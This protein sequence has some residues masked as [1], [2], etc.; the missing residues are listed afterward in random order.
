[1]AETLTQINQRMM[2]SA[3]ATIIRDQR[4]VDVHN[5]FPKD[6][7]L[8]LP[9]VQPKLLHIDDAPPF[10]TIVGTIDGIRESFGP[11]VGSIDDVREFSY[12]GQAEC[13]VMTLQVVE[14]GQTNRQVFDLSGSYSTY[15]NG[16]FDLK[17]G[18]YTG[19]DYEYISGDRTEN[20]LEI[21]KRLAEVLGAISLS[22]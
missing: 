17:A 19:D 15:Y 18:E 10:S 6:G 12:H 1:M 7:D 22:S 2:R 4:T 5:P 9:R 21:D 16:L 8:T 3:T 13:T 11:D 14:Q 20:A